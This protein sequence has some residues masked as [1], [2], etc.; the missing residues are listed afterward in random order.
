MHGLISYDSSQN[1]MKVTFLIH[2]HPGSVTTNVG[3]HKM[4]FMQA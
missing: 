4:L 1:I 2:F 3:D